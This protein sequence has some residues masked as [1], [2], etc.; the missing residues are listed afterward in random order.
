MKPEVTSR[1]TEL[2][3]QEIIDFVEKSLVTMWFAGK[4]P[5]DEHK[6]REIARADATGI[7]NSLADAGLLNLETRD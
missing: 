6:W 7:V 4:K 5:A 3:K 1:D 2:R